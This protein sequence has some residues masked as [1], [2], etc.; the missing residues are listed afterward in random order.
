MESPKAKK[1]AF[2]TQLKRHTDGLSFEETNIALSDR[3]YGLMHLRRNRSSTPYPCQSK[4]VDAIT[5]RARLSEQENTEEKMMLEIINETQKEQKVRGT[6]HPRKGIALNPVALIKSIVEM[7]GELKNT[8]KKSRKSGRRRSVDSNSKKH[9]EFLTPSNSQLGLLNKKVGSVLE[10]VIR[11]T[12]E[13]Q[14]TFAER[15]RL[16]NAGEFTIAKNGKKMSEL[17]MSDTKPQ[18]FSMDRTA[19]EF[20]DYMKREGITRKRSTI[21][22][23]WRYSNN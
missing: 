9:V 10:D 7:Q 6:P 21:I 20:D 3:D 19:E 8:E 17:V 14:L 11:A 1:S 16:F 2:R 5:L 22:G 4:G 15:R 12:N 23:P 18:S 13:R